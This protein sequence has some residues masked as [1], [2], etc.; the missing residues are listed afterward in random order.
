MAEYYDYVLA[1]VPVALFGVSGGLF[2]AGA[3]VVVAVAAASG[4]VLGTHRARDVRQRSR[5]G[6]DTGDRRRPG[7]YARR[8]DGGAARR[9]G[10]LVLS[11][12]SGS[13]ANAAR[14]DVR[15]GE[16]II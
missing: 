7:H 2:A 8:L 15:R 10:P 16:R 14:D 4:V 6:R 5:R 11:A 9:L 12:V 13:L 1:F 3:S